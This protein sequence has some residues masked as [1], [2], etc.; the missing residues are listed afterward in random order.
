MLYCKFSKKT[1]QRQQRKINLQQLKIQMVHL[2]WCVDDI[3]DLWKLKLKTFEAHTLYFMRPTQGKTSERLVARRYNAHTNPMAYENIIQ[4][5]T[6]PATAHTGHTNSTRSSSFLQFAFPFVYIFV[7][8]CIIHI[9][10]GYYS[11]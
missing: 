8:L 9:F 10:A 7:Y 11:I 5:N 4:L 6:A 3:A 1:R 2:E